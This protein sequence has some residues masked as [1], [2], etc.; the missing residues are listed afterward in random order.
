MIN[1][2]PLFTHIGQSP[3]QQL[4]VVER[5]VPYFST[6]FHFHPECE[7]VYI[8][9]GK[10][11]RIV[12][13]SVEFFYEGDLVF[14]GSN[15][16]HVWYS[17]EDYYK[18]DSELQSRAIVVYFNK[19]IF[20][21][22]FYSLPET[23]L[24][25]QMYHRAE[26]GMRITGA[27]K[28]TVVGCIEQMPQSNGLPRIIL[29]LE[30]M[31]IL[32]KTQEFELLASIGYQHTYDSKDNHK[33]DE[34]FQ[35]VSKNFGHEISLEEISSR[36]HLTPQSFCRFFKKRT[37][38]TFIDFLS[39]F[40]VSHAKKLLAEKEETGIA[41]IAYESGFNNISNFNKV[42]KVKTGLTPKEYKRQLKIH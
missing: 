10:G 19:K 34:V 14:L 16:P 40:R 26:R 23:Q 39:E 2:K 24:L 5:H 12:G 18:D 38:K 31:N 35:Y 1:T 42:F 21:D 28:D 36:C 7:L 33:L 20:G 6:P 15:I 37:Q 25:K 17:D 11:K 41:E 8:K 27:A 32:A 4:I 13:D 30:V 22:L 9:E 3:Q 29:L